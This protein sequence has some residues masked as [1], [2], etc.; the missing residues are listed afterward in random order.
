MFE[1]RAA[2]EPFDRSERKRSNTLTSAQYRT[3]S[4]GELRSRTSGQYRSVTSGSHRTMT[5]GSYRTATSGGLQMGGSRSHTA[6]NLEV[7]GGQKTD[8]R[9]FSRYDARLK[10][11]M[12]TRE[13]ET[14]FFTRSVG[15]SGMF[16]QT[17]RPARGNQLLRLRVAIPEVASELRMLALVRWR[18]TKQEADALGLQAGM[19]VAFYQVPDE[20]RRIWAELVRTFEDR[21]QFAPFEEAEIRTET[22]PIEN[23][24]RSQPRRPVYQAFAVSESG[25]KLSRQTNLPCL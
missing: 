21:L 10:V 6:V 13:R 3:L 12:L 14:I 25:V 17:D 24:S 7:H 2:T 1:R 11:R 22:G 23:S 19:G 20:A 18:R 9:R 5:S 15:S 4:G 8:R 16:I